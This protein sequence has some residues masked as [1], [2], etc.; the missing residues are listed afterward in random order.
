MWEIS[1]LVDTPCTDVLASLIS[2]TET[3]DGWAITSDRNTPDVMPYPCP[4]LSNAAWTK[5]S[6]VI[7]LGLMKRVTYFDLAFANYREVDKVKWIIYYLIS[8][9]L[10]SCWWLVWR[11]SL[12]GTP[13]RISNYI[14]DEL[15]DKIT[16]PFP[17]ILM[18]WIISSH[19]LYEMRLLIHASI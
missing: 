14:H 17:N 18:G 5:L 6:S 8:A 13:A 15:W 7:I 19:P 3:V 10:G 16:N 12:P 11:R 1:A 2:R 4:S 9:P